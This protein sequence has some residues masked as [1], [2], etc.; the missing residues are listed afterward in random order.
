MI[1]EEEKQ[2]IKDELMAELI[3]MI[4]QAPVSEHR[5]EGIQ[6]PK[7]N[8]S[9]LNPYMVTSTVPAD[10]APNGTI[11]LYSSSGTYRLYIRLNNT[12]VKVALT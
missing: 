6:T 7:I 12:W 11:R 1:T 8:S 9:D 4:S 10:R 5:H 2:Q 3:Q